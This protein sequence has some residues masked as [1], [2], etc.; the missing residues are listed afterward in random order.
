MFSSSVSYVCSV[1]ICAVS[2]DMNGIKEIEKN[3]SGNARG[4][5]Q[6]NGILFSK[7]VLHCSKNTQN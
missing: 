1:N 7:R 2:E 6:V 3:L 4:S 5:T